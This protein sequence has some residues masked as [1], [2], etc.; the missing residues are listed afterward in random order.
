VHK[1][2]KVQLDL[3]AQSA[4]PELPVQLVPKVF[5]VFKEFLAQLDLPALEAEPLV[6]LVLQV[7]R[8]LLVP[9]ALQEVS[10]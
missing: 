7:R 10:A 4:Q 8:D 2:L 6:Q 5:K 3:L 9:Q 1:V